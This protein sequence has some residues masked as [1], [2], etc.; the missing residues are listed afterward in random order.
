MHKHMLIKGL[1]LGLV[2]GCAI[3]AAVMPMAMPSRRR[4]FLRSAPVK[5][6]VKAVGHML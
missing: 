6:A 4:R 2:A 1:G 5:A 3:T